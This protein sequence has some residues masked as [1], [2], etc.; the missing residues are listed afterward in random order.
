MYG[1]GMVVGALSATRAMR[2]LPFGTV[3]GL[4]PVT[5]FVAAVVWR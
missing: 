1:V 3:I 5:G 4:G 2:R